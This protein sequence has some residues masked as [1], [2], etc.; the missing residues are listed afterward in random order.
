MYVLIFWAYVNW[1]TGGVQQYEAQINKGADLFHKEQLK[2]V[3]ML[4][5]FHFKLEFLKPFTLDS[6]LEIPP[7]GF[8]N[9]IS[10]SS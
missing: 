9:S 4:L 6:P 7:A 1:S 2:I 5:L 8:Y 3:S 10:T